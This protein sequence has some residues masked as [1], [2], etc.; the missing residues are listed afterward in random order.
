MSYTAERP[1][2]IQIRVTLLGILM[3]A[4]WSLA[5]FLAFKVGAPL[6]ALSL[7]ALMLGSYVAYF[8]RLRRSEFGTVLDQWTCMEG[9]FFLGVSAMTGMI[10][11]Y[12]ML[13]GEVWSIVFSILCEGV[14]IFLLYVIL[15][16][17][18]YYRWSSY[19]K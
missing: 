12:L 6:W 14:C 10:G 18:P 19:I 16:E 11:T 9:A 3:F 1:S 4:I 15:K 8:F 7:G 5:G 2:Y 13:R 17:G